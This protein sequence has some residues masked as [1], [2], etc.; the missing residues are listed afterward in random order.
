MRRTKTRNEAM[1][2]RRGCGGAPVAL[3]SLLAGLA[4]CL[5]TGTAETIRENRSGGL[6]RYTPGSDAMFGL[7]KGEDVALKKA[8]EEAGRNC[9]DRGF[10]VLERG[11]VMVGRRTVEKEK[12]H[13]SRADSVEDKAEDS[14][15][16]STLEAKEERRLRYACKDAPPGYEPPPMDMNAINETA[17][18]RAGNVNITTGR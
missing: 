14:A 15:R 7:F 18:G 2:M 16:E 13:G 9:G 8:K 12:T 4:G 11:K 10:E 3:A 5:A 17:P 1:T 6:V